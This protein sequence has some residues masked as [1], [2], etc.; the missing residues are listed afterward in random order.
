MTKTSIILCAGAWHTNAHIEPVIPVFDKAGYRIVPQLL[1]SSG[2]HSNLFD[3]DV[4]AIEATTLSELQ[5]GHNVVLILHSLAGLSGLEAVNNITADAKELNGKISRI[6]LLGSFL[7]I[8][9]I[10]EHLVRNE[11]VLPEPDK[12]IMWAQQGE[13]VFYNDISSE[14]ARPFIEALTSLALYTTPPQV[15]S[16][17]WQTAAPVTYLLCEHDNTVPPEIGEKTATEYGMELVRM[18]AGHCPYTSQPEKFVRVVDE[19]LRA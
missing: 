7:D 10:T 11:F 14:K 3:D 13:K 5:D 17:R 8:E 18:D 6:I 19:I 2:A 12:G 16:D 9:P 4:K 1:P 15:S